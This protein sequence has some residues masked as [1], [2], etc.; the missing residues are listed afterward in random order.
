MDDGRLF[1]VY[2]ADSNNL[3]KPDIKS[4]ILKIDSPGTAPGNSIHVKGRGEPG[5]AT[6]NLNISSTRYAL[7]FRFRSHKIPMGSEF[8]VSLQSAG[9]GQTATMVNWDLPSVLAPSPGIFSGFTA[10]G[11]FVASLNSFNYDQPYRIHTLVDETQG[12]QQ[13]TVQDQ[14]GAVLNTSDQQPL[15]QNFSSHVNSVVIG[16]NGDLRATDT[17]LDFIFVHDVATVEPTVSVTRT[18]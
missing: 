6:H 16:N 18:R 9:S 2:Y 14:F 7:D 12:I 8:S 15:A 10:N 17:L 3:R 5:H 4:L 13:G 11:N 1:V